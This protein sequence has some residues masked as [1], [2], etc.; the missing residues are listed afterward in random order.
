[1]ISL[2]DDTH[3]V[4]LRHEKLFL[5]ANVSVSQRIFCHSSSAAYAMVQRGLGLAL[6]EPFSAPIWEPFGV[7]TRPFRP[8]LTYEFVA[9]LKPGVQQSVAMSQIIAMARAI[10]QRFSAAS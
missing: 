10:F 2:L 9:G 3:R 6:M 8:K 1:M 4:F 5:E 7:V